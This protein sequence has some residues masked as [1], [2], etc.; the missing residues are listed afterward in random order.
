[1][2]NATRISMANQNIYGDY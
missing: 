2:Y 1:V